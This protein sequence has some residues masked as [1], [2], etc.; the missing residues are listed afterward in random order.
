MNDA[1]SIEQPDDA[2][3]VS[4]KNGLKSINKQRWINS[5][6]LK[7]QHNKP[8]SVDDMTFISNMCR[9]DNNATYGEF[10]KQL[11]IGVTQ[12][13]EFR[14]VDS[15]ETFIDN[16]HKNILIQTQLFKATASQRKDDA[17]AKKTNLDSINKLSRLLSKEEMAKLYS[18]HEAK[19]SIPK[20]SYIQEASDEDS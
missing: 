7:Y 3:L 10:L 11:S 2:G 8:L 20:H 19:Q 14:A 13:P 12:M 9:G 4:A 5:I 6:I 17:I 15:P 16:I 18:E 1:P